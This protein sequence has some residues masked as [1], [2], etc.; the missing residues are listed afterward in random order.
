MGGAPFRRWEMTK[1]RKKTIPEKTKN[2]KIN[3]RIIITSVL[4]IVIPIIILTLAAGIF[5]ATSLNRYDFSSVNTDSYNVV[6]Q[7]QWS[8]TVSNIAAVLTGDEDDSEKSARIE[9]IAD[10]LEEFGSILYI[11]KNGETYYSTVAP[12]EALKTANEIAPINK[13][14]NSYY[15]GE[16]G[17]VIV[18]TAQDESGKYIIITANNNYSAQEND[19]NYATQHIIMSLTNN[20]AVV[21]GVCVL[22]FVAAIIIISLITSKTIIGPIEKIT[23][24]ANEIAKGNL[25]YEIDY[26]ST[27]E[28]GQ[29]AQSFNDMRI[30]VKESIES[31]NRADQ[32]QKE[33]IAGIAHDLRTPLTSIKGYL[34]G[35]KDGVADT[36]EKQKRYLETIYDSAV[37][38]EKMLNDLLTLSKLELGNITLNREKVRISDFITFALEIG[39]ELKKSDFDFEITDNTK[40]DPVLLIDTDRFARVIDN[41]ISNSIKY[42]RKNVRGRIELIISEY[43]HSVIFEIADNGMG[44]DKGSLSRIFDTL[45]RA[46]KARS[47]VSDGSGL[48]LSVCRQIVELHGG[49]IWAQTNAGKGLSIFISLPITENAEETENEKNTDN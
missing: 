6:N 47:N 11:E 34:E 29:L 18:S 43:E 23:Q 35:I 2:F 36:P 26:Q 7:I 39:S 38:M 46:D 1:K 45:Y 13:N 48:G 12:D 9:E 33:M 31:K 20:A 15:Y 44:V 28:L 41:I 19:A 3:T 42:R 49:M 16:S 40:S 10:G 17:I 4:A 27:N 24:G 37:S 14:I 25:D 8:Q 21:L 22:T 5:V 30:R 32:Q